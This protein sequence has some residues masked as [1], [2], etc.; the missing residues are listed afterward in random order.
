MIPATGAYRALVCGA[1]AQQAAREEPLAVNSISVTRDLLTGLTH[2]P[3]APC[4]ATGIIMH[5][6]A[7]AA[8]CS[9]IGNR[10]VSKAGYRQM[11][12][13]ATATLQGYLSNGANATGGLY[14]TRK[15]ELEAVVSQAY[16]Y[17]QTV[18]VTTLYPEVTVTAQDPAI[19]ARC[20]L[21]GW[22]RGGNWHVMELKFGG[23]DTGKD[24][25]P[26]LQ[27]QMAAI[28]ATG[29][30]VA[31]GVIVTAHGLQSHTQDSAFGQALKNRIIS[32]AADPG[33]HC[34]GCPYRANCVAAN[35]QV[36]A[37]L[38]QAASIVARVVAGDRLPV[39][40]LE[41][42]YNTFHNRYGVEQVLKNALTKALEDGEE[43]V[44]YELA[45]RE[46]RRQEDPSS[47][48]ALAQA[49]LQAGLTEALR[50]MHDSDLDRCRVSPEVR[51]RAQAITA[52]H[53]RTHPRQTR[54]VTV[55][56]QRKNKGGRN[57]GN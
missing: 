51:A 28:T 37:E 43:G 50:P 38:Q 41:Q 36:E 56:R 57:N 33:P 11:A 34:E 44:Q 12:A 15:A 19:I 54:Q 7:E 17:C 21:V 48:L 16:A 22:S 5:V 10:G 3:A 23:H 24:F 27:A 55:L 47:V 32:G 2:L 31:G 8:L 45:T 30:R 39:E 9:L 35:L 40:Q 4:A 1:Y 18:G 29:R 26:Q 42:A 52:A 49:Y 53:Y 46:D 25:L 14:G 13:E 6:A 20:D